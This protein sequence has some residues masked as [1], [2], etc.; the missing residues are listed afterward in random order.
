VSQRLVVVDQRVL[1]RG[2]HLV[3][4]GRREE[5]DDRLHDVRLAG[6]A[7][8]LD[9]DGGEAV[10]QA[11]DEDEVHDLNRH[12]LAGDAGAFCIRDEAVEDARLAGQRRTLRPCLPA[13]SRLELRRPLAPRLSGVDRRPPPLLE[14]IG[15]CHM[16]DARVLVAVH[17]NQ[18]GAVPD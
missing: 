10:E 6:A 11:G 12:G 8:A 18:P 1:A 14:P 5:A 13:L 15:I 16:Q 3:G 4:G 2:G 9:D 7:L 17:L